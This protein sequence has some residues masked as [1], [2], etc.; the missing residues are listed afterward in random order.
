[1]LHFGQKCFFFFLILGL[2]EIHDITYYDGSSDI[3]TN[4]VRK[5]S[6]SVIKTIL[7]R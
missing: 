3:M 6:H 1:M 2:R 4:Y 5:I 7:V